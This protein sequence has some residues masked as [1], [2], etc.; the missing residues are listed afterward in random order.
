MRS[1]LLPFL[2]AAGT[3]LVALFLWRLTRP[4]TIAQAAGATDSSAGLKDEL[5]S[6]QWFAQSATRS[7]FAEILIARAARSARSL[8]VRSLF[9]L[10][11]PLGAVVAFGL[12]L[13]SAVW[14]SPRTVLP[15]P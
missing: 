5:K 9:P 10:G 14:F 8:N 13:V 1:A 15:L 4:M 3:A 6:A 2:A 12:V 11:V 7:A